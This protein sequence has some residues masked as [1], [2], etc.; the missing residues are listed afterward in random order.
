MPRSRENQS[1]MIPS[2][3]FFVAVAL[4]KKFLL[5]SKLSRNP[6]SMAKTYIHASSPSAKCMPGSPWK[7]LRDVVAARC[8]Q[9]PIAGRQVTAFLFRRLCL[10]QRSKSQP[11]SVSAGLRQWCVLSPLLFIVYIKVLHTTARRTNPTYESIS[12][13]HKTHFANNEKIIQYIYETCVD[14]VECSISRKKHITQDI[15]PSNCCAIA[16][17]VSPK[18]REVPWSI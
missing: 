9:A 6:G 5:S 10:C 13:G 18:K 15:W 12:P 4:Q 8:W 16:Y 2:A 11:F 14:L 17:V 3:V 7:A 1:W